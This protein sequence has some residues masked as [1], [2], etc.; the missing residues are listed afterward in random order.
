GRHGGGVLQHAAPQAQPVVQQRLAVGAGHVGGV[1]QERRQQRADARL[2][3]RGQ[4][5]AAHQAGR[6]AGARAAPRR[7]HAPHP[8]QRVGDGGEPGQHGE[9][10]ADQAVHAPRDGRRVRREVGGHLLRGLLPGC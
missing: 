5:Q 3:H 2:G 6:G 10:G 9:A 4:A 8:R 1:A 7:H